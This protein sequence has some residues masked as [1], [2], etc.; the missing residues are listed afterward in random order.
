MSEGDLAL[1]RHVTE[2]R[3]RENEEEEKRPNTIGRE[4]K[5]EVPRDLCILSKNKQVAFYKGEMEVYMSS[6]DAH[7]TIGPFTRGKLQDAFE[8]TNDLVCLYKNEK[9]QMARLKRDFMPTFYDDSDQARIIPTRQRIKQLLIKYWRRMEKKTY[10]HN[11]RNSDALDLAYGIT[12]AYAKFD[13]VGVYNVNAYIDTENLYAAIARFNENH[14]TRIEYFSQNELIQ[15]YSKGKDP[16]IG[17]RFNSIQSAI[18]RFEDTNNWK[19]DMNAFPLM[20]LLKNYLDLKTRVGHIE[21]TSSAFNTEDLKRRHTQGVKYLDTAKKWID[22]IYFV[23][24]HKQN[25]D[26][27]NLDVQIQLDLP[28]QAKNKKAIEKVVQEKNEIRKGLMQTNFYKK[29][30]EEFL[31]WFYETGEGLHNSN[32]I[33]LLMRAIEMNLIDPA[34]WLIGHLKARHSKGTHKQNTDY[35]NSSDLTKA[36]TYTSNAIHWALYAILP[37]VQMGIS[38]LIISET[39]VA[40]SMNYEDYLDGLPLIHVAGAPEQQSFM[41]R[42]VSD[43]LENVNGFS[44]RTFHATT[45]LIGLTHAVNRIGFKDQDV[46][47]ITNVAVKLLSCITQGG[48]A[49]YHNWKSFFKSG[50]MRTRGAMAFKAFHGTKVTRYLRGFQVFESCTAWFKKEMCLITEHERETDKKIDKVKIASTDKEQFERIL[51]IYPSSDIQ[52][53]IFF[54]SYILSNQ[55]RTCLPVYQVM[56]MNAKDKKEIDS[57]KFLNFCAY[58]NLAMWLPDEVHSQVPS[59]RFCGNEQMRKQLYRM[60]HAGEN[61]NQALTWIDGWLQIGIRTNWNIA[62][63]T[64]TIFA[65]STYTE[66]FKEAYKK[67]MK[68][69]EFASADAP[70]LYLRMKIKQQLDKHK[71]A[72]LDVQELQSLSSE[73]QQYTIREQGIRHDDKLFR[74]TGGV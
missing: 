56:M 54:S 13:H 43:V 72:M 20:M 60:H 32:D 15:I 59:N 1:E 67:V 41:G 24:G 73:M 63:N 47:E 4:V 17:D 58:M 52:T 30:G 66:N 31:D 46:H 55:H 29:H 51:E 8:I 71:N 23:L 6:V 37:W 38:S 5:E 48:I 70:N 61:L 11:T 12:D 64:D 74:R 25:L 19:H 9:I 57:I 36:L 27:R 21:K 50:P 69:A 28:H 49:A 3:L 22:D 42:V 2:Q 7:G 39:A 16:T 45:S 34:Q 68:Q 18:T 53:N 44:S 62:A 35:I 26:S 33:S 14:L 40:A 65:N 10:T